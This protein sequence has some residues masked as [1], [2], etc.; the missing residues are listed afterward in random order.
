MADLP[1]LITFE[2]GIVAAERPFDSTLKA[3][4]IHY[5]DIAK[6]IQSDIAEVLVVETNG[7]VV[8]SG[9]AEIL[10][11]EPYNK[12]GKYSSFRFMYVKDAHRKKGLNKMILDGLIAWSDARGIKEIKLDVYDQNLPALY[13]YLKAGFKKTMVEMHLLR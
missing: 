12:F 10:E 8:A 1:V 2:Q 5:Y 13:A 3:G 6:M 11:T 7:E 4:E 9:F